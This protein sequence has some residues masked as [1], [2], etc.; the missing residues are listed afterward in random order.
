VDNVDYER[1]REVLSLAGDQNPKAP[2]NAIDC[3]DALSERLGDRQ[4]RKGARRRKYDAQFRW[5]GRISDECRV[6]GSIVIPLADDGGPHTYQR[7]DQGRM[8][9]LNIEVMNSVQDGISGRIGFEIAEDIHGLNAHPI[10]CPLANYQIEIS[11]ALTDRETDVADAGPLPIFPT[12][13]VARCQIQRC[14]KIVD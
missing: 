7:N 1:E 11:G 4:L 3:L 2:D 14:P 6:H 12:N 13:Q 9:I 8:L 5:R 10:E